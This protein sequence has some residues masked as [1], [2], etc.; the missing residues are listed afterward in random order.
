MQLT[1][2]WLESNISYRGWAP[3]KVVQK[4]KT[5]D[6]YSELYVRGS[7]N[8]T[9]EY[10]KM[11]K[12][13]CKE[14][15][16]LCTV[17]SA[18]TVRKSPKPGEP[19]ENNP[20]IFINFSVGPNMVSIEW[21]KKTFSNTV[22][23]F[24]ATGKNIFVAKNRL[25]PVENLNSSDFDQLEKQLSIRLK[26]EGFEYKTI[27]TG[28]YDPLTDNSLSYDQKQERIRDKYGPVSKGRHMYIEFFAGPK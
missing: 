23:E 6:L 19:I 20:H 5:F 25:G 4:G 3:E 10:V 12:A 9:D 26:N 18:E 13:A 7:G 2:K 21:L 14:I 17:N 22:D 16:L 1:A 24:E 15:G 8:N 28:Q 11:L 27:K